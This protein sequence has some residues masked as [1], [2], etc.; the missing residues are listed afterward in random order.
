MGL[1]LCF[2]N[3]RP[4]C[5]LFC[6]KVWQLHACVSYPGANAFDGRVDSALPFLHSFIWT[7]QDEIVA[8]LRE[9]QTFMPVVLR[10]SLAASRVR[11]LSWSKCI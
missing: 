4:V 2:A 9:L 10:E 3:C 6:E 5:L 8:L 11:V 1:W 7:D